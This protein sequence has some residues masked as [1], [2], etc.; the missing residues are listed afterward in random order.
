MLRTKQEIRVEIGQLLI[1]EAKERGRHELL[2]EQ[3]NNA[4]AAKQS[5]IKIKII[6]QTINTLEWT[7]TKRPQ[8]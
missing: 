2:N 7:L 1:S 6:R 4:D 5:A 3:A 8:I